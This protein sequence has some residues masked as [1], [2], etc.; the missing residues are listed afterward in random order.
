MMEENPYEAPSASVDEPKA[1]VGRGRLAA[2]VS[3]LG[4]SI[5]DR[6]AFGLPGVLLVFYAEETGPVGLLAILAL[7]AGV[8]GLN[9]YWWHQNGQ[10]IGKRL[11]DIRIVRG[12]RSSDVSLARIVFLRELPVVIASCVG[13][14]RLIDVLFIFGEKRQCLH[15]L[16]ADT[17]VIVDGTAGGG[18]G[19]LE[20]DFAGQDPIEA[21]PP[22]S[23]SDPYTRE[24]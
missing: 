3:R 6:A 23:E 16:L 5:V 21:S 11:V 19:Y 12:D 15:D 7:L 1:S 8:L 9:L 10:S 24:W 20:E 13:L 17:A 18:A 2:R 22:S 14:I 4:A